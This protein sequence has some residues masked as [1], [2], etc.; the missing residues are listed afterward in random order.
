M[1]WDCIDGIVL[2]QHKAEP[3]PAA[4]RICFI[5]EEGYEDLELW[6]PWYAL[7]AQGYEPV[8]VS[9]KSG[10]TV[11]GKHG[12]EL[13]ATAAYG[14]TSADDYEALVIPGGDSPARAARFRAAVVLVRQFAEQKKPIAAI[15]HGPLL[16]L[17]AGLASGNKLTSFEDVEQKLRKGG[18]EWSDEAALVDGNILTSRSPDDLPEFLT[19]LQKLLSSPDEPTPAEASLGSPFTAPNA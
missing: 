6:V 16:L 2:A 14:K 9:S 15:C 13:Q 8:A 18:A 1:Q 17:A 19:A 7:K 12:Y 3:K 10:Q 5:V 4:K 11:K